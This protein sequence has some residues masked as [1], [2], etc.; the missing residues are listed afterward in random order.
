M[1]IQGE[2]EK[3][4]VKRNGEGRTGGEPNAKDQGPS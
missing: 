3:K 4:L 2:N 1:K